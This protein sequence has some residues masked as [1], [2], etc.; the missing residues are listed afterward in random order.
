MKE[1][2][3]LRDRALLMVLGIVVLYVVAALVWFM[4]VQQKWNV[5][6]R[7]YH[8][9]VKK[10]EQE[11]HLISQTDRWNMEYLN[12]REK[13]PMFPEGEDVDTHWMNLMDGLAT[14]NYVAISRRQSGREESKGDV[15]E[16][17][18]E[19]S[20]WE[21][22]LE[23]LVKFLWDLQSDGRAMMDVSAITMRPSQKKG[24]LRGTFTLTCAYMRGEKDDDDEGEEASDEGGV[25]EP[26]A[27]D[28]MSDDDA[29]DDAEDGAEQPS[30]APSPVAAPSPAA[31]NAADAVS[32]VSEKAVTAEGQV[33]P[34][35][36]AA[37]GTP[38][39]VEK[40]VAEPAAEE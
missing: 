26:T 3:S 20:G 21:G 17:P 33:E 34:Q 10:Y 37:P 18:I 36:A 4:S 6:L 27:A 31:T 7:K 9:A 1:G 32:E 11:N 24:F 5:S 35:A 39:V 2:L 14:S 13:M 29:Q 40:K 38:A 19:V 8:S 30:A 22:S 28:G 15:F 25:V 23:G 12:E 16:L